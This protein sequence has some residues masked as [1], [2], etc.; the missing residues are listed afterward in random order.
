MVQKPFKSNKLKL[1]YIK[2]EARNDLK[3]FTK[4]KKNQ[5]II[6]QDDMLSY[7]QKNVKT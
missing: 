6:N 2:M 1:A 4:L 3:V 5:K 7:F